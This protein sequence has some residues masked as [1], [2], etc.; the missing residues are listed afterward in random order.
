MNDA[1][2]TVRYHA[3]VAYWRGAFVWTRTAAVLTWRADERLR[4]ETLGP[5]GGIAGTVFDAPIAELGVA[6][7]NGQLVCKVG[8]KRYRVEF[9]ARQREAATLGALGGVAGILIARAVS[10]RP[11]KDG[12]A[13]TWADTLRRAG[14]R[15]VGATSARTAILVWGGL[16]VLI[17]G[18]V[19]LIVTQQH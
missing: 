10:D 3:F 19:V 6:S 17:A 9:S 5:D 15:R 4:L 8:P 18:L 12:G 2:P 13:A 14:A 16:A 1:A 11:D 7:G